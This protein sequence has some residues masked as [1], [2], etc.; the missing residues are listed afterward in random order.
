VRLYVFLR[1]G[2]R[3]S[4]SDFRWPA[5]EDGEP[6]GWV[7]VG[8]DAPQDLIRVSTV[9]ELL[10]WLDD[11]LWEVELEG[12]L[13]SEGHAFVAKRGRLLSRVEAWTPDVA[14]ELAEACAFRVRD[15]GA[16][17]LARAGL[18]PEANELAGCA[19]LDALEQVGSAIAARGT[20]SAASLAGF[21]ADAVLYARD[22]TAPARAAGVAAY[23]AAHALAGGDK[24]VASYDARFSD[25][26]RWQAEWLTRRLRLSTT[27]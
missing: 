6:G 21:A 22:A 3:A 7:E 14:A 15:A 13:R 11:E 8:G 18:A 26:R 27:P 4:L 10:W 12:D 2:R 16:E 25:E 5:P 19:S 9:D 23:V 17:A 1:A 24:T 20:D